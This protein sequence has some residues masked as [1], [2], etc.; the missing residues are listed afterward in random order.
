ME[1][2]PELPVFQRGLKVRTAKLNLPIVRLAL[3]ANLIQI[4]AINLKRRFA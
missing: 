4:S 1:L 3:N 2:N